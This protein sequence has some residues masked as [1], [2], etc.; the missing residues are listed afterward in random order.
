MNLRKQVNDAVSRL[1]ALERRIDPYV[2]PAFDA[3]V[4]PPVQGLVQA[5]VRRWTLPV[6]GV[7]AE[8]LSIPGEDAARAEIVKLMSRFVLRE[9][10]PGQA[11]RAGNTKTY[12]VVRASL[13]VL[14]DLPFPVR[15]GL[16]ARP[17]TYAAWVRFAGPGPLSP[18]DLEDNGILS[19]GVKVVGVPGPK[20]LDDERHTQD[21]TGISAPTFTTPDVV[22]NVKLQRH[23]GNGTPLW[24]FLDPRDSHLADLVMQGLYARTHTS[25]LETAYW[26]CAAYLLG[27]GQAMQYRFVPRAAGRTRVPW[28]PPDDY[29]A[30]ALARTLSTRE[31][32]FDVLVQVQNDPLRMPVEHAS[33]IWPER[34]SPPVRVGVLRLPVQELDPAE[35]RARA[36]SLSINPW[37]ALPE[38][39]P[40]G[41]QNRARREIYRELSALRQDMNDVPHVEPGPDR[42]FPVRR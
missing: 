17:A 13:E 39:R 38:H 42:F 3:V 10:A 37:H 12:G 14:D 7:R 34:V 24:Y 36:D 19:I 9:Y 32:E 25:P 6:S 29:L 18:P 35:Q 20:L 27:P 30:Q 1:V 15:H 2:R 21:F 33:V 8:E 26:S 41:N 16:F 31:A 28:N 40:L 11:Q 4:R 5:L 22:A 23:I